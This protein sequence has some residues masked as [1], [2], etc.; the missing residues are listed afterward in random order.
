MPVP[1]PINAASRSPSPRLTQSPM[2]SWPMPFAPS[3]S[4]ILSRGLMLVRN[5]MSAA[6]RAVGEAM[7]PEVPAVPIHAPRAPDT[8][9]VTNPVPKP[10][11]TVAPHPF[12]KSLPSR[13]WYFIAYTAPA[14]PAPSHPDDCPSIP[15][16]YLLPKGCL[17]CKKAKHTLILTTPVKVSRTLPR[18]LLRPWLP[19]RRQP[20]QY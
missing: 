11:A 20:Q 6:N 3:L 19:L 1:S 10:T 4:I 15:V 2:R 7:N 13:S 18:H 5:A 17:S 9:P 8:K 14:I 12:Q 16:S